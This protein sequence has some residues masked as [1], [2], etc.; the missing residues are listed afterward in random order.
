MTD[1][2][3]VHTRV[4]IKFLAEPYVNRLEIALE[5]LKEEVIKLQKILKEKEDK[6]NV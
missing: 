5:N 3:D 6:K 1:F 4:G 2:H